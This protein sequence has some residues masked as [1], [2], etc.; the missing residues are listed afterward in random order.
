[1]AQLV[2]NLPADAGD[3]KRR[4]FNPWVRKTPLKKEMATHS[5]ILAWENPM[6]RGA[7][8]ATVHGDAK[9]QTQPNVHAHSP[10]HETSAVMT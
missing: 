8:T 6:D 9:S 4:V 5:R 1:M 3:A 2:K 10:I 7:W